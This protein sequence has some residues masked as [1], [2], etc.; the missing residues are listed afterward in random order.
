MLALVLM[1]VGA[2]LIVAG[3]ATLSVPAAVIVCGALVGLVG[4]DLA[5]S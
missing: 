2:C 5:R 1:F 3:T 4:A